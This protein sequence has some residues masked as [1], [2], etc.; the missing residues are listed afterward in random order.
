[1]D[2]VNRQ[3]AELSPG[4]I[5]TFH[6]RRS[7]LRKSRLAIA[8]AAVATAIVIALDLLPRHFLFPYIGLWFVAFAMEIASNK[9]PRCRRDSG[10]LRFANFFGTRRATDCMHCGAP[11]AQYIPKARARL[12]P[13][14]P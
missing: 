8:G 9:C 11:L 7:L 4:A 5:E 13:N 3:S 12:N 6:R 2:G 14:R 10:Y 1:V